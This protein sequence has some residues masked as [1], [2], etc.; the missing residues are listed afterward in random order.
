MAVKWHGPMRAREGYRHVSGAAMPLLSAHREIH[1]VASR[2]PPRA[3]CQSQLTKGPL[4]LCRG[5]SPSP[6]SHH[7]RRRPRSHRHRQENPPRNPTSTSTQHGVSRAPVAQGSS[8]SR[9]SFPCPLKTF[10][11]PWTRV[12]SHD[13]RRHPLPEASRT[14]RRS[15]PV[16]ASVSL[17]KIEKVEN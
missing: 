10:A 15:T 11:F 17:R 7:Y 3:M 9:F 1:P 13:R 14:E 12:F 4:G 5:E 6:R 2:K 16:R 8:S